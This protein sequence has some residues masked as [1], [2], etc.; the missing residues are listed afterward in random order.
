LRIPGAESITD[1]TPGR[2][3]TNIGGHRMLQGFYMEG[4]YLRSLA[5]VAL[6]KAGP[7]RKRRTL[8]PDE[9]A[10]CQYARDQLGGKFTIGAIYDGRPEDT[11][12]NYSKRLIGD[13]AKTW[14]ERGW[15][16]M[17]SGDRARG[18]RMTEELLKIVAQDEQIIAEEK[19]TTR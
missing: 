2:F 15:L 7:P 17:Q 10:W 16:A 12:L 9:L 4:N 13:T 8:T 18:Y 5:N 3:V 6:A 1:R 11:T 14:Y 19:A